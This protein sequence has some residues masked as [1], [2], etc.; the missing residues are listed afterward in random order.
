MS[1]T[2]PTSP[3]PSGVHVKSITPTLASTAH[4]LKRQVRSRGGQRWAA[5]LSYANLTRIEHSPLFAFSVDQAGQFETFQIVMPGYE[6]P[7]GTWPGAPAIN[8]AG[9]TGRSINIKG[10]TPSTAGIAKAGDFVKFTGHNKA[11]MVTADAASNGTGLATLSIRPALMVSPAD[12]EV[13]VVRNVPFTMA[14]VSDV[15]EYDV[16][17]PL[18]MNLDVDLIEVP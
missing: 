14:L 7:L 13:L 18:L 1:G 10:L 3:R 5:K 12:S 2:Y 6:L 8:G 9:Q 17:P 4:S 16:K 11:Y 15:S